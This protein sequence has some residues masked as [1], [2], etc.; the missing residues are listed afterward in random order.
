MNHQLA[1]SST[2]ARD[3]TTTLSSSTC[4]LLLRS[5]SGPDGPF[6]RNVSVSFAHNIVVEV[7]GTRLLGRNHHHYSFVEAVDVPS[8]RYLSQ[9][10]PTC[11]TKETLQGCTLQSTQVLWSCTA[12][13][14]KVG[15]CR[16]VAHP[17]KANGEVQRLRCRGSAHP[18]DLLPYRHCARVVRE[19]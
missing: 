15:R 18:C 6:S 8:S 9:P 19:P 5:P 10:S 14:R 2:L 11:P 13:P 12:L 3:K 17:V 7:L 1:Q 16:R 4:W